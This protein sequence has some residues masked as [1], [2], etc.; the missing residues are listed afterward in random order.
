[1]VAGWSAERD[2]RFEA[3][4]GP[5]SPRSTASLRDYHLVERTAL[6]TVSYAVEGRLTERNGHDKASVKYSK[7]R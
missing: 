1:M 6:A 4:T 2:V 3:V 5:E 7:P